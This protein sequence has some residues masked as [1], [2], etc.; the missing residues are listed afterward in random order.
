M[1]G[2]IDIPIDVAKAVIDKSPGVIPKDSARPSP[3]PTGEETEPLAFPSPSQA[4]SSGTEKRVPSFAL[5]R[6]DS[7]T[8]K[9]EDGSQELLHPAH[10]TP[11]VSQAGSDHNSLYSVTT[12]DDPAPSEAS[13]QSEARA[14]KKSTKTKVMRKITAGKVPIAGSSCLNFC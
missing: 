13:I 2:M 12:R 7:K 5:Q 8:E 9:L 6:P 11:S 3:N 14:E 10:R 4:S 1:L